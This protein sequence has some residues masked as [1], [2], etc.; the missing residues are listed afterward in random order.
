MY[1][2]MCVCILVSGISRCAAPAMLK[3]RILIISTSRRGAEVD[4]QKGN[5]GWDL[6]QGSDRSL[7]VWHELENSG[8]RMIE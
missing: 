6:E 1:V 7:S 3:V 8:A 2:H 4:G 5:G